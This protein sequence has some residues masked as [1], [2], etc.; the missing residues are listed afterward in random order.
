MRITNPEGLDLLES[1]ITTFVAQ[2]MNEVYRLIYVE[3]LGREEITYTNKELRVPL[4][5]KKS[6]IVIMLIA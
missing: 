4:A 6:I 2:S 3:G 1:L 5:F